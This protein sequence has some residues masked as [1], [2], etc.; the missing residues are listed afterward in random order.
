VGRDKAQVVSRWNV[1]TDAWVRSQISSCE[2][3]GGQS[4]IRKRFSSSISVFPCQY[5][6]I[7]I[8]IYMLLLLEWKKGEALEPFKK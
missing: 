2:I 4:G 7:L 8:S 5:C 3:C 1:A 6:S